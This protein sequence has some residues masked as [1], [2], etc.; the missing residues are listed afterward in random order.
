MS[1]AV[2]MV[3]AVVFRRL[4]EGFAKVAKGVADK[5]NQ[6]TQKRAIFVVEVCQEV[7]ADDPDR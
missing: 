3:W 7:G 5:P 4:R 6:I 1:H 2:F